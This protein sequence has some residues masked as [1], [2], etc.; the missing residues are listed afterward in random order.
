MRRVFITRFE[1]GEASQGKPVWPYVK[2][3]DPDDSERKIV[4]VDED[5]RPRFLRAVE[6]C[7]TGLF[8][9]REMGRE[10]GQTH[11]T[12]S[13]SLT[14]V[15]PAGYVHHR[16]VN[17]PGRWRKV[18]PDKEKLVAGKH[19]SLIDLPTWKKIQAIR[20]RRRK[21]GKGA[22]EHKSHNS[23]FGQGFLKCA[24]CGKS[25]YAYAYPSGTLYGC[26]GVY[27]HDNGCVAKARRISEAV[28]GLQVKPLLKVVSTETLTAKMNQ[29]IQK[30]V[31][32]HN[33]EPEKDALFSQLRN[34]KITGVE[35]DKGMADIERREQGEQGPPPEHMEHESAL[36]ASIMA[37]LSLIWDS[38][39]VSI[40]DKK[41]ALRAIFP[42]GLLID[43]IKKTVKL[44]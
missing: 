39:E 30:E 3:P 11:K 33:Y 36:R 4:V 34:K 35:F 14:S 15:F 43:L 8:S 7:L 12:I 37:S 18:D 21:L 32:S 5:E 23:L 38:E 41:L 25:L 10:T 20:E 22:S 42:R 26:C 24:N 27:H 9:D 40:D 16:S 13:K 6:M 17:D 2:V 19:E 28:L 1:E 31:A 29:P 44:P